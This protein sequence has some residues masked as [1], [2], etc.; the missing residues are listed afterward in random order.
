M[1]LQGIYAA[2]ALGPE[3][4]REQAHKAMSFMTKAIEDYEA[5]LFHDRYLPEYD[6]ERQEISRRE[7]E[8]ELRQQEALKARRKFV[9]G[10]GQEEPK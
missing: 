5:E 2:V 1:I 10:M 4:T 3:L 9:E 8:E 7:K 6:R